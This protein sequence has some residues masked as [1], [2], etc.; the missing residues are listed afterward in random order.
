[1]FT[2]V[3]HGGKPPPAGGV[4]YQVERAV[5][6]TNAFP[7]WLALMKVSLI[8]AVSDVETKEMHNC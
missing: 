7:G 3:S 6:K 8:T 2:Y 1:M 4:C 5:L